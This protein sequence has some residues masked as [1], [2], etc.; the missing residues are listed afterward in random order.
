[1]YKFAAGESLSSLEFLL[2]DRQ[3]KQIVRLVFDILISGDHKTESSTGR[4]VAA[5]T[6]L[7]GD[8]P[9][10]DVDQYARCEILT[11]ARLFLVC[12]LFQQ[13]LIQIAEAFFLSSEP[14]KLIDGSDN[15]SKVLR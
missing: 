4:V 3:G 1:M 9:G 10:H 12:V 11:C 7:R 5:L 6:G 15:F 2:L 14:V 13:T 8:Q